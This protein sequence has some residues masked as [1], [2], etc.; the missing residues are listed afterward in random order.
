MDPKGNRIY[1]LLKVMQDTLNPL[2]L[3]RASLFFGCVAAILCSKSDVPQERK[4]KTPG[5]APTSGTAAIPSQP[6]M[7]GIAGTN[8]DQG[9]SPEEGSGR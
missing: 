8:W 9:L 3:D 6:P 4:D 5:A 1:L 7:F 2:K